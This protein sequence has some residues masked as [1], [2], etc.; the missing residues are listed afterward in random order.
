M[1]FGCK[2]FSDECGTE[3]KLESVRL[4]RQARLR[5]THDLNHMHV[6]RPESIFRSHS[7]NCTN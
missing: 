6:K 3:F 7:I 2:P 4:C 5:G 1:H